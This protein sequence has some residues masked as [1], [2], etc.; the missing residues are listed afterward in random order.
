MTNTQS[1][2]QDGTAKRHPYGLDMATACGHVIPDHHRMPWHDGESFYC[3]LKCM[4]AALAGKRQSSPDVA[5]AGPG[6]APDGGDQPAASDSSSEDGAT[7]LRRDIETYR[8]YLAGPCDHN[9]PTAPRCPR[10]PYDGHRHYS[11]WY[12][13]HRSTVVAL[14][15]ILADEFPRATWEEMARAVDPGKP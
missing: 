3:S 6:E 11:A 5:Q 7:R 13:A 9:G 2:Q 12:E 10:G 1:T 8:A 15:A 14:N 4:S